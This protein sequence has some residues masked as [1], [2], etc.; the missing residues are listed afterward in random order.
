MIPLLVCALL[1]GAVAVVVVQSDK[2]GE[3]RW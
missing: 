1:L 2:T 3:K